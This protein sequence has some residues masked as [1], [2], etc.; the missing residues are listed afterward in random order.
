MKKKFVVATISDQVLSNHLAWA[1]TVS[2]YETLED[3]RSAASELWDEMQ[4][5]FES[6]PDYGN[7]AIMGESVIIHDGRKT[8]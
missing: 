8:Y 1:K 5:D 4:R 6:L 7:G 2:N 3:A